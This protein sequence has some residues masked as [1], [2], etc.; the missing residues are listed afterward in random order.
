MNRTKW[1]VVNSLDFIV[2]CDFFFPPEVLKFKTRG[3]KCQAEKIEH[4]LTVPV[5]NAVE[6]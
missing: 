3:K 4:G 2:D 6:S 1:R 5:S